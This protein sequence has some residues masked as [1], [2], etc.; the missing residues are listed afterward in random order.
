MDLL[1]K[2]GK[3]LKGEILM[4][5]DK[6]ISHRSIMCAALAEGDST[7]RGFLKGEDCLATIDA[8]SEMGVNIDQHDNEIVVHGVGLKG[9][10]KP[11]SD[12]YL[13]N[14]GTSM[15]LMSGL[16][17]GQSFS[18]T[19]IGDASLSSRPMERIVTPLKMM[20]A[21]ISSSK[22]G[23]P[24]LEINPSKNLK[25]FS[26]ELPIASA[27]VKSCLMFAGLYTDGPVVIKE[28]IQTRDHTELMFK[29]FGVDISIEEKGGLKEISVL[30]P[31]SINATNINIP[32]DFS[33][34]AF[35]ILGA[36]ITPGSDL[37]LM[38]IGI[39]KTRIA[40]LKVFKE[41][42][43]D[44]KLS[45]LINEHEPSADIHIKASELKGIT[46]DP[47]LVP[48]L[49]DEM[50]VL[51]IAGALAEGTTRIRGAQEL[52]FKESDR[53]ES[54]AKALN[55][56]GVKHKIFEDGID[57]EGV[58]QS[59]KDLPFNSVEIDSCGDHRIA[60][61]S[62]IGALRSKTS[63]KIKNCSNISTSFP[64]FIDLSKRIGI[65]LNKI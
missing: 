57:I 64:S 28:K 2:P 39:N 47:K 16:L 5:G 19:L 1:V 50:P 42:G 17:C 11:N 15:R 61:A 36:L 9:L 20:G 35:F 46:L 33:S 24:P 60:M 51:F 31:K 59:E 63:C 53:L 29:K 32:G 58:D 52:R 13:G 40:L 27:Q 25:T 18:S 56:F 65:V 10:K 6:S 41:M 7:V 26:Y 49:I 8:F 30:P 23:C 43:A 37:K 14:S 45:N 3:A 38:N 48:N 12:I 21:N 54:M 22:E 34:A 55:L 4:P 44:I 62:V